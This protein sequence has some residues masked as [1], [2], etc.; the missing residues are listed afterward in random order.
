[1]NATVT[2]YQDSTILNGPIFT[3]PPHVL[4]ELHV[5]TYEC[6]TDED[7]DV[8][9]PSACVAYIRQQHPNCVL[10]Y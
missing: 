10:V 1:M 5:A 2:V 8:I 9:D 4:R 6:P 3:L 7:G